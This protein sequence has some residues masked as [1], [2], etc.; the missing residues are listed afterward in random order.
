MWIFAQRVAKQQAD[1]CQWFLL[2]IPIYNYD[3]ELLSVICDRHLPPNSYTTLPV[4]QDMSSYSIA[5]VQWILRYSILFLSCQLSAKNNSLHLLHII[6]VS[7]YNQLFQFDKAS[8]IR[9]PRG[10]KRG[11]LKLALSVSVYLV[12]E[13]DGSKLYREITAWGGIRHKRRGMVEGW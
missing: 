6:S 9:S 1:S 10:K 11:A 13:C 7:L 8:Y 2:S 3:G 4:R 5:S 12:H